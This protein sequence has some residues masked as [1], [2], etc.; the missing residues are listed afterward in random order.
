MSRKLNSKWM[1]VLVLAGAALAIGAVF[2]T[3]G[4]GQASAKAAPANTAPPTISG[5]TTEGSTLTASDGTWT[6][7][8]PITYTYQWQRCDTS[9]G[10]C[11]AISGAITKTYVL[12]HADAGTTIRV[13][14]TATNS[15]G[16][17]N[18][19]SVPT[20]V[21]AATPPAVVNGCPAGSGVIDVKDLTPPA[22]LSI[23]TPTVTPTRI[24]RSTG[25]IQTHFKVTACNGRPVQNAL[26]YV[27]AVPFN[28][29][30]TPAEASTAA[31][32]TANL[33]MTQ[34]RG[35]PAARQQRLLVVFSRARKSGDDPLGGVST[36]LLS[37]FPVS[38]S[39]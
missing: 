37:S 16:N 22:R 10:S 23:S 3:A 39:R 15:D 27:S 18:A 30:S 14:V 17:A 20:A 12:T 35:F 32:G 9:G 7:T 33:T 38:L 4:N 31:D 13:R 21:I 2:G 26:V 24:T 8:T 6:G 25:S 11:A 29:F 36:R 1:R 28:Q 34:L 5:T 19:T